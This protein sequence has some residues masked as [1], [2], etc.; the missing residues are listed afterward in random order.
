M[1]GL[2][3]EDKPVSLHPTD[4][5]DFRLNS[6]AMLR[7]RPVGSGAECLQHVRLEGVFSLR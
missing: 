2:E 7:V 5:L 3:E 1:M 6:L 4:W